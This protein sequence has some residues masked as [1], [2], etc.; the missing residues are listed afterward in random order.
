MTELKHPLGSGAFVEY[1]RDHRLR[2][3]TKPTSVGLPGGEV[4]LDASTFGEL[5]RFAAHVG[6]HQRD[7]KLRGHLPA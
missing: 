2:I 6:L 5:L 7:D 3:T 4:Y 1:T